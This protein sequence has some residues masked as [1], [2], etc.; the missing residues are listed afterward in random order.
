MPTDPRNLRSAAPLLDAW[1]T[2]QERQG[3]PFTIPGHKHRRDLVGDV[4]GGDV[5]L[6]AG[7][8]SMKLTAGTLD[9]AQAAA[10]RLWGAEAAY[11]SVGGSTHGT[12]ALASVD[13][14]SRSWWR[15]THIG[16]WSRP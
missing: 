6:Y 12:Q 10:A 1:L 14:V 13:R 7:L 3:H 5:P 11:F 16:R 9:A 2:F 8:D 4:I 15:A